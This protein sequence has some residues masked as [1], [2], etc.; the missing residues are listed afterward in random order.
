MSSE[1]HSLGQMQTQNIRS[2]NDKLHEGN[3][4]CYSPQYSSSVGRT[5]FRKHG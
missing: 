4:A 5:S 2:S 1:N 3:F